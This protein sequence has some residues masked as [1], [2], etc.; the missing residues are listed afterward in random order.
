[1]PLPKLSFMKYFYVVFTARAMLS[2]Y[3]PWPC[4]CLCPS[5]VGVLLKWL[6]IGTRKQRHTIAQGLYFS[7][8]KNLFEIRTGSPQKTEPRLSCRCLC[9]FLLFLELPTNSTVPFL[10]HELCSRGICHGRVSVCLC[11]CP[12]QVGVLLKWLNVGTRKQ[13]HT[14]AQGLQFSDAK[15]LSEIRTGSPPTGA[16]NGGG[17]G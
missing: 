4:V 10:P 15:N 11:V 2:R 17:V 14:I 9:T 6:N 5:Q 1:M 16:P 3:M 13:R 7:D 12:S 8:A